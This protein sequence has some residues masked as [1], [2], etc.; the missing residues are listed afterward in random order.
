MSLVISLAASF[1]T[2]RACIEGLARRDGVF[3]RTSKTGSGHHRLRKALRLSLW[4]SLFAVRCTPRPCIHLRCRSR[5]GCWS[6]IIT[7]QATVY[8]CAP[9]AAVWNLRTQRVPAHAYRHRFEQ[10]RLREATAWPARVPGAGS[11]C[12]GGSRIGHRR[13]DVCV[14]RSGQAAACQCDR[15]ENRFRSNH[16]RFVPPHTGIPE[17]G[18]RLV[19]AGALL[20][21]DLSRA[22]PAACILTKP[23]PPT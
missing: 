10:Q 14:R 12:R 13:D 3:L 4:E 18:F 21:G 20:P 6:I 15:A 22:I 9:I 2:A 23:R 8:L 7:F 1:V 5:L 16:A 11:R 17:P 19:E